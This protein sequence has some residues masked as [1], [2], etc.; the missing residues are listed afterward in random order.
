[1]ANR[2]FATPGCPSRIHVLNDIDPRRVS[3]GY[4]AGV[5]AGALAAGAASDFALQQRP[6]K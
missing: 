3:G 1:M 6:A 2:P 4:L 5:W